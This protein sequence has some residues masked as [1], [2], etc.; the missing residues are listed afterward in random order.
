MKI[1][2]SIY[3][4]QILQV[5]HMYMQKFAGGKYVNILNK[6]LLQDSNE[7]NNPNQLKLPT[8]ICVPLTAAH[9]FGS[10]S[11]TPSLYDT[12]NGIEK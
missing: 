12:L 7:W 8:I 9:G 6:I 5:I 3:E 11:I 1:L 4:N 2:Q 10:C